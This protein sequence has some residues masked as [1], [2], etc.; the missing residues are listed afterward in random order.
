MGSVGPVIVGLSLVFENTDGG[1]GG[2]YVG[3]DANIDFTRSW[4]RLTLTDLDRY[5]AEFL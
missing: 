1:I 4:K 3:G 5:G 2:V